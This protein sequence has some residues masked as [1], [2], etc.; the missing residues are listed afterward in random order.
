VFLAGFGTNYLWC[1]TLG[2]VW[3]TALVVGITFTLL[4]LI[5]TLDTR[6]PILAGL[7][8][9]CAFAT[10]TP[11]LFTAFIFPALV[12]FPGGRLRREKWGE[13]IGKIALFCIFP[14][15][16]GSAL[17]YMNYARFEDPLEFGHRYLAQGG[18]ERIRDYGLFNFHYL[19]RNLAAAFTL[20][21]R[22]Q[23]TAPYVQLSNHGMSLFLTT[24][25][26][27][28]LFRS[29][30]R[31]YR[32]DVLL[33]RLMWVSVLVIAI[34]HFF[35]QNTG[36]VQFGYRFSMDYLVFLMVILAIGRFPFT[37]VFSFLVFVGFVV[38]GFGA[39]TFGR[40]PAFYVDWFFD[41]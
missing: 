11:L 19:A 31:R 25:V 36:W 22:I 30:P 34:P 33:Y 32:Q 9:A 2:Q 7:F 26:F 12:M 21:P 1:S 24:P 41:P 10:R 39:I 6:H 20:L 38:C 27:F 23:P 29:R 8:L 13:A 40:M 37:R 28:Y 18:F 4:Y 15:I 14:L 16:I 17:L 35:Y 3:F 5:F